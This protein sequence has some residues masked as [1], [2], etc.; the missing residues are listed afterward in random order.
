MMRAVLSADQ[1]LDAGSRVWEGRFVIEDGKCRIRQVVRQASHLDPSRPYIVAAQPIDFHCHGIADFDFADLASLELDAVET[2]LA[3]SGLQCILTVYVSQ[4]AF[5]KLIGLLEYSSRSDFKQILGIALEGPLLS[6]IGGTPRQ[7]AWIPTRQQW[8]RLVRAGSGTLRYVVLSPDV[9]VDSAG[10]GSPLSQGHYLA[11]VDEVVAMLVR[12][13][14]CP[15]FGHFDKSDPGA[16]AAAV[17]RLLNVVERENSKQLQP[18]PV[19]SD[20][21]MNDMP[22]LVRYAWRTPSSRSLRSEEISLLRLDEW[23]LEKLFQQL[24]PVP[25]TLLQAAYTGEMMACL[26]F[27]GEHV[28][29]AICQ[30]I[31]EL[32]GVDNIIAITDRVEGRHLAGRPLRMTPD[33]TL[34][35]QQDGLVA[36]GSQDLAT[37]GRNMRSIGCTEV[38]VWKLVAFNPMRAVAHNSKSEHEKYSYVAPLK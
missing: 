10:T 19:V 15:A 4:D 5:E 28:D 37:Q 3:S 14:I 31:V 23:R 36:A 25:A 12:A 24:G 29:L 9:L 17:R 11:T 13:G 2:V 16:S 22:S 33:S 8:E 35:Y 30:R 7:G 27:D 20:H 18:T 21:L 1:F 38:D 6:S 26:N 32:I 34:L